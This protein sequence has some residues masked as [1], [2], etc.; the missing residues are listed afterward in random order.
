MTEV[1]ELRNALTH[2]K[3]KLEK[4]AMYGPPGLDVWREIAL[5]NEALTEKSWKYDNKTCTWNLT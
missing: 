1:E 2:C 5:A 4:L 3:L